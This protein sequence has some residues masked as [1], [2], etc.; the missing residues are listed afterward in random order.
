MEDRKYD[1]TPVVVFAYIGYMYGFDVVID[2][3]LYLYQMTVLPI[4]MGIIALGITSFVNAVASRTH[5]YQ[6]KADQD[7]LLPTQIFTLLITL[8]APV[9][10][11]LMHFT[12]L[13]AIYTTE[14]YTEDLIGLSLG[15]FQT[16]I[17]VSM[18]SDC[19]VSTLYSGIRY[20]SGIWWDWTSTP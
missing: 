20:L 10:L 14:I 6:V 2:L 7:Y 11:F 15:L 3:D 5:I 4:Q 13:S 19:L 1:Y 12:S 18:I 9:A 8:I 17:I 16:L